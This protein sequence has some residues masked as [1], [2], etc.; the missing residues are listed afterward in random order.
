MKL[1]ELFKIEYPQTLAYSWLTPDD[2]GINFVS[3]QEK[4]NGVVGKVHEEPDIKKYP[5]GCITVPLKGS[6]LQAHLQPEECYV[7]HQI[8]VLIPKNE[9]AEL[10]KLFYVTCIRS[11]AF[12]YNYG[13][14]ADR[15]LGDLDVP[16]ADIKML[17]QLHGKR[18]TTEND[19]PSDYDLSDKDWNWFKLGGESGLFDIKKGKRLT[20]EDQT[21]G[22][23]PY[24]GA[25]DS[26]NG[27]SN[28]IG[29]KPIH[30][31]NT[32]S[33]S[34]NGSVGEAFYQPDDYW[35]TDDV[36]ALYLKPKY[37]ELNPALALF[38]CTVIKLDKYRFSYGR[39]WTLENMEE[40]MIKLPVTSIG[41]PDWQFMEDYMK[42]L[43]YGDRIIEAE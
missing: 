41:E 28:M 25:I 17:E 14:Q 35:A 24:I 15:T 32:I 7:A 3:S 1:N 10:E 20:S 18:I 8:G 30:K 13:R 31:G 40:T 26:N 11:H 23:T 43:P 42:S 36:N 12:K 19:R 37:G 5:A 34:Y 21:E 29:Q 39:K 16:L 4:N 27:V 33:L 6:V 22:D 9:M 38:I 2:A